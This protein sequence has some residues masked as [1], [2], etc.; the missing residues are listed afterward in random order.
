[1]ETH[2][3]LAEALRGH[4]VGYRRGG[5]EILPAS[6]EEAEDL[7]ASAELLREDGFEAL[8]DGRRLLNPR[9]GELDPL[10]AVLALAAEAPAAAIREGVEVEGLQAAADGVRVTAGG[11]ECLAETVV[12]ATNAYTSLLV[13]DIRI[14]P[15]RAQMLGTAPEGRRLVERPT[16]CERGFRYWRQLPDRRLLAGGFRH[17]ALDEEVGHEAVTTPSIQ[18]LLEGEVARLG[19]REPVTHR[20]AGIMGF[21]E[22]EL[23]LVGPVPGLPGV[24]LCAGYSGH[25]MGFAFNST[26]QLVDQLLG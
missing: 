9:D 3:L 21:T 18:R 24:H 2:D 4:E 20:W 23:P 10:R 13:P 26:R 1:V 22:E 15:V 19:G 17:R 25:G 7:A 11:A 6:P 16:Y 5:S 8:W 12:L 14:V